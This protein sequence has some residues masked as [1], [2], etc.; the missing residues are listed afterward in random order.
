MYNKAYIAFYKHKR[1]R[2]S[3]K[4]WLFRLFDDIT[5]FFTHGKYS[6]CELVFTT[7]KDGEYA[8]FTSSNR[9]GG[10]RKKIMELPSDRWDLIE[11]GVKYNS[12]LNF[13]HKTI[14][15]K[16]D[17][18]GAIGVV[19]RFGNVK[20]RYFCSEW[21]AEALKL[22]Q[23]HKYSPNSLYNYLKGNKNAI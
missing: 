4:D 12:I 1:E 20:S 13:Y 14:G 5:K 19:T 16:Y 21:C 7:N 6:H 8:C 2:K 3:L 11:I 17:L 9:D 18:C 15:C 10:V 22:K 23:P